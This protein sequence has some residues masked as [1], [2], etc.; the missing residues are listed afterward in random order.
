VRWAGETAFVKV[1]A[2]WMRAAWQRTGEG[3][4]E[5]AGVSPLE[6]GAAQFVLTEVARRLGDR[7]QAPFELGGWLSPAEVA[8]LAGD[9]PVW[10]EY[11]AWIRAASVEA[12][13]TV[14]VPAGEPP[15]PPGLEAWGFLQWPASACLG[16]LSLRAGEW[17]R[18]EAG[19]ALVPDRW[20]AG[21]TLPAR[22]EWGEAWLLVGS[23]WH[24]GR[25][26][27]SEAGA[28]LHLDSTWL[29]APGGE[30]P[31]SD[32]HAFPPSATL[33]PSDL[34]LLVTVELDRFPVTL[35]ELQRWRP[36]EVVSLR[37]TPS[38]TVRL[39]M[40]TGAQ[41]RVLAEGRVVAVG[42]RLG[43]EVVRLLTRLGE[44]PGPA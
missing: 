17:S 22:G 12:P 42:D 38:D 7:L 26:R 21:T 16:Q 41:R 14:V 19:D 25:Y 13:L 10:L 30:R 11:E 40:D 6:E 5:G 24:G 23:A 35:A 9:E 43:V 1:T 34:E 3:G 31:M 2:P 4:D 37:R 15:P 39:V 20:W 28:K 8:R 18:V 33:G 32:E 29:S 27:L 36:G 44:E